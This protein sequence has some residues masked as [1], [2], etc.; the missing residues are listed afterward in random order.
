MTEEI[1]KGNEAHPVVKIGDKVHRPIEFWHPAVRDLLD[2]L[3]SVDFPYSPKFLGVDDNGREVL[4][5]L[6]GD[7]GKEGWKYITNDEGLYRYAKFLR[8]YHD[9][10]KGYKPSEKLEW[11]NG[12]K[13]LQKGQ[14]ICHGDFGP[15]NIVWDIHGNPVG[16]VD[17]DLAHPN[18]PEHDIL[19]ALEYSAPFRDD[20]ATIKWHHFGSVPDRKRRI[21]IF[22]EAYGAPMFDDVASKVSKM[23]REVNDF[24]KYL[25]GRGIQPQLDWLKNGDLERGEEQARWTDDN[26]NLF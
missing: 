13:G 23:Q 17:W 9:A 6:N 10:V 4:S 25:A 14:I 7:S 12:A 21:K 2:Y 22:L 15:W 1:L 18:S 26:K 11:A 3:Q 16:I 5:F 24:A 20:K 19:Y 8:T